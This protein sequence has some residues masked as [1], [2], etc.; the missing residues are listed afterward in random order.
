[1]GN[2]QPKKLMLNRETVRDLTSRDMEHVAGGKEVFDH[3]TE[4][5][6]C[7]TSGNPCKFC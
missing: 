7:D 2:V 6:D 3:I 4:G 5:P 1:M